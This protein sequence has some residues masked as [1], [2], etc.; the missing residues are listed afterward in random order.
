MDGIK[1]HHVVVVVVVVM[2]IS[3]NSRSFASKR[4]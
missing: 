3:C 4:E 1:D 2:A